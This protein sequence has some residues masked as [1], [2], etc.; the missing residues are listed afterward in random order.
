VWSAEYVLTEGGRSAQLTEDEERD[1]GT[2][3]TNE[4]CAASRDRLVLANL[5]L[6]INIAMN[7]KGRGL[8]CADLIEAAAAGLVLAVDHFDPAQGARFSTCASWWVKHAIRQACFRP[9]RFNPPPD[10]AA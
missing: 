5:R 3:V 9:N 6:A 4:G 8:A 10:T 2:R 1:L 7:Y